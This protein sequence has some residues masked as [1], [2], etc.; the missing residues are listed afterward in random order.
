MQVLDFQGFVAAEF[1]SDPEQREI[2]RGLERGA[3]ALPTK[4]ST[5]S[6]D[7]AG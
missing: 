2:W 4:L 6:V 3:G 5:R 1:L 7:C